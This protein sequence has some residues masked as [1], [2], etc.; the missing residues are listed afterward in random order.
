[1]KN[2]KLILTASL[3]ASLI[4]CINSDDYNTPD[5]SGECVNI[6]ATKSVQD[7]AT[8]ANST[9]QE[10]TNADFI[11]AYV[12]S[13][14]EGGNFYKS[15]SLVSLDGTR[16]FTVPVDIYNLYTKYEPGRKVT[17]NMKNRHFHFDNQIASL[18]IG[19]L[20]NNNTPDIPSDDVV[21]RISGVEY[22]NI[23]YRSCTKVNEDTFI[24][25]MSINEAK[26]NQN[27]NML[28]EF[29][30]VQFTTASLGKKFY[31]PT[32]N[33]LGGATNHLITDLSGNTIILRVSEY[34]TFASQ[35]ISNKSGKIRGVLTK[36]DN[37]FQFMVRTIN[38]IKLDQ[39][40]IELSTIYEEPFTANWNN[41]IKQSVTGA[42]NWTLNTT[43]G[44]PGSCAT[45]NGFSGG[46]Q[47]NED[48]LISPAINLTNY[49]LAILRFDNSRRFAGPAIE[50]FVSTNY[51][52]GA[53]STATW[54]QLTGFTLD[55][56]TGSYVWTNSGGNDVSSFIGSSNFRVAFKYTSTTAGAS[57]WQIDNV[58]IVGQ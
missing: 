38:D 51:S 23:I 44:N 42:Q 40:R 10:Y 54:T 16:G 34:A 24:K 49:T 35:L 19:S 22:E 39:P 53:P 2:F 29:D 37:D 8:L 18:E 13:S 7:I 43:A 6:T 36:Y 25:R 56:N 11:E 45:M 9:A 5:L 46:N 4:G 14:D 28:I 41:W 52:S 30:A 15:I 20:Y 32:L 58:R 50:V 12:T 48:W 26:N 27:I 55:T 33:S 3:L 17:I 57:A 1:M 47:I 31:D 21:G